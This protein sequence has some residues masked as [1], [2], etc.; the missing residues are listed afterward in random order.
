MSLAAAASG[1]SLSAAPG[2]AVGVLLILGAV[3]WFNDNVRYKA[4]RL[5]GWL[6]VG[7][8]AAIILVGYVRPLLDGGA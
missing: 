3:V 2:I 6:V 8:I 4:K 7:A 5:A 1:D